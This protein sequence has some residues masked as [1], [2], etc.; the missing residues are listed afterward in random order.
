M[1]ETIAVIKDLALL[2]GVK[3]IT[4]LAIFIIGRWLAEKISAVVQKLLAKM[5]LIQQFSIL[6]AV[7]CHGCC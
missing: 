2:Y 4:A 7:W 5:R 6:L 3:V 1:G